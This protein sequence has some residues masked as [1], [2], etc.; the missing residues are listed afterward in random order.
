MLEGWGGGGGGG[1]V[2][3]KVG[4]NVTSFHQI[5]TLPS[6]F[7]VSMLY[8]HLVKRNHSIAFI[9]LPSQKT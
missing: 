6:C 2:S 8:V 1:G 3:E 5:S 7:Y 4:E 9:T